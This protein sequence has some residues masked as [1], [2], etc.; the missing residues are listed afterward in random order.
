MNEAK[1]APVAVAAVPSYEEKLPL[2]VNRVWTRRYINNS[3]G[4]IRRVFR[5]GV[6]N[7]LVPPAVIQALEAIAPLMAG[8]T[9]AKDRAARK[10]VDQKHINMVLGKVRPLIGDLINLQLLTG[11]RSGELLMLTEGMIDC[12]GEVWTAN[13]VDHKTVHHGKERVLVFGPKAQLI[14]RPY[15]TGQKSAKLF[16]IRRDGYGRAVS[17]ACDALEISRWTPHWLRHTAATRL[18]EDY[19]LEAAQIMLGHARADM[20][21]LYAALSLSK[22]VDVARA[23]G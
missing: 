3:L 21:Q 19:G 13:L 12:A 23:A 8:R 1:G 15:F 16:R 22:A 2:N 5:W 14:L 6:E 20:T 18:R 11:A 9:E 7:E 17:N 10:P 4:R